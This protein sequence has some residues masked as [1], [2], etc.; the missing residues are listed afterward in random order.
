LKLFIQ[1]LPILALGNGGFENIVY[2]VFCLIRLFQ[3]MNFYVFLALEGCNEKR[4]PLVLSY[5]RN[6]PAPSEIGAGGFRFV[7]LSEP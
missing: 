2:F 1:F 7:R 3:A 6:P 4:P 5:T